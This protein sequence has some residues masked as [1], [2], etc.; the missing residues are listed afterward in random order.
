MELRTEIEIN[1]KPERVWNVLTDFDAYEQWNPFVQRASG[2]PQAGE[3]LEV[4]LQPVG[5]RGMTLRPRVLMAEPSREF[6]WL[7]HLFVPGLFD[8]E[9]VFEIVPLDADSVRLVQREEFH[10]ILAPLLFRSLETPTRRGFEAM[11]QALK[12]R[13]EGVQE[14]NHTG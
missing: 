3:Q 4:F 7:G 12:E 2:K 13:S 8:G 5:G 6:R 10:G 11:N 9:H 1:A 14:R